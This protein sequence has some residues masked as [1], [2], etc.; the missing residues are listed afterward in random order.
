MTG[1]DESES[2]HATGQSASVFLL[3]WRRPQSA[4]LN[5]FMKLKGRVVSMTPM[6]CLETSG[7]T[8]HCHSIIS[9]HGIVA[10]LFKQAPPPPCLVVSRVT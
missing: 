3:I 5:A 2:G 9:K 7:S 8:N 6:G 4:Q 1:S 10:R